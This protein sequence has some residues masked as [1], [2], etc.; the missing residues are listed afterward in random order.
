MGGMADVIAGVE[1]G[2]G[3]RAGMGKGLVAAEIVAGDGI[4]AVTG[5]REVAETGDDVAVPVG[6]RAVA[7][8]GQS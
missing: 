8:V 1:M 4:L 2:Q 3:V 6:A 5:V 7:V